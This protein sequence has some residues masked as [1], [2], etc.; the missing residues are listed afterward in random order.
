MLLVCKLC[1]GLHSIKKLKLILYQFIHRIYIFSN[2]HH[3]YSG[4][5][6][7][8]AG[9]PSEMAVNQ[10]S[11]SITGHNSSLSQ[12][13]CCNWRSTKKLPSTSTS[14]WGRYAQKSCWAYLAILVVQA[15]L[16]KQMNL[17]FIT[18]QGGTSICSIIWNKSTD[19]I[20]IQEYYWGRALAND[21]WVF[22]MMSWP[23]AAQLSG[24]IYVE[25]KA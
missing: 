13:S 11:L 24:W 17:C 1:I 3:Y 16:S 8:K 23:S 20:L 10:R 25:G 14:D 5:L 18:N 22:G 15:K 9:K 6:F 21:I 4:P 12:M 2:L 7:A 19:M